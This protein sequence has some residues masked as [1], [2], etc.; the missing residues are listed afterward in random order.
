MSNISEKDIIERIKDLQETDDALHKVF[1]THEVLESDVIEHYHTKSDITDVIISK[2]I[3]DEG[4]IKT[5]LDS[6]ETMN[7]AISKIMIE[8]INTSNIQSLEDPNWFSKKNDEFIVEIPIDENYSKNIEEIKLKDIYTELQDVK[9]IDIKLTENEV[10]DIKKEETK[11]LTRKEARKQKRKEKKIEEKK[12]KTFSKEPLETKFPYLGNVDPITPEIYKEIVESHEKRLQFFE[13]RRLRLQIHW[14]LYENRCGPGVFSMDGMFNFNTF[15]FEN[16]QKLFLELKFI[17]KA[18][19]EVDFH[20]LSIWF[21][22]ISNKDILYAYGPY[23]SKIYA[24]NP[25]LKENADLAEDVK[26]IVKQQKN[27]NKQDKKEDI[28]KEDIKK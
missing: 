1:K 11:K 25:K 18:I 9:K 16:Y 8:K 6:N 19:Y 26:K 27:K 3:I 14:N 7:G 17:D 4:K 12:T 13:T 21:E 10:N 20:I 5:I 22:F 23:L 28:K 2:D 24:L 15:M